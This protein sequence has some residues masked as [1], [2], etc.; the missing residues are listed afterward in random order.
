M[1]R[2]AHTR[3]HTA[4]PA[5]ASDAPVTRKMPASAPVDRPV[6]LGEA[7]EGAPEWD[8][9]ALRVRAREGEVLGA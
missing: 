6:A 2:R 4:T 7:A 8:A 3:R 1:G 5:N 9:E